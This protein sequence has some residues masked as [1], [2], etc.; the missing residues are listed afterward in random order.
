MRQLDSVAQSAGR[1]RLAW[2]L[3]LM[4]GLLIRAAAVRE[5]STTI[6]L[7]C[8]TTTPSQSRL[9]LI[10]SPIAISRLL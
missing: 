4:H 7:A 1:Q 3:I 2:R 10:W 5:R 6:E 9:G 8:E